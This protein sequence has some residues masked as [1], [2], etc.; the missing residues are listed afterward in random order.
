MIR[1]TCNI[2]YLG[3]F[4]FTNGEYVALCPKSY[5][6][7]NYDNDSTKRSSKGI[8]HNVDVK[9]RD[10]REKLFNPAREHKIR[11][12]SLRLNREKKMCRFSIEKKGLSDLYY[13]MQVQSDQ[14]TCTPISVNNTYI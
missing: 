2:L 3:E 7:V 13:K 9:M 12:Q 14:I 8:P 6:V 11:L 1:I 10:Y 5:Y 4:Q